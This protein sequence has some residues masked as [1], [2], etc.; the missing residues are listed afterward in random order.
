MCDNLEEAI[1]NLEKDEPTSPELFSVI[2]GW[3]KN[4]NRLKKKDE[5]SGN[6]TVSELFKKSPPPKAT[7]LNR[8]FWI[9]LLKL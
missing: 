6:K 5:F 2:L 3:V 1:R 7:K 4:S 8:T 9:S